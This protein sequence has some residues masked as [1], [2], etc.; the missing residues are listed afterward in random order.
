MTPAQRLYLTQARSD[1][2]MFRRFRAEPQVAPC[3]LLH[4]LQMATELLGKASRARHGPVRMSHAAFV[5]LLKEVQHNR[6]AQQVCGFS[7]RQNASWEQAIR[8]CILIAQ[9][10]ERL[11]PA[12]CGDGPNPEY[13]WPHAEAHGRKFMKITEA[14]FDH[15]EVFL[16]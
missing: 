7:E 8:K 14:L 11:A 12:L 3:H 1:L 6:E 5:T 15:A 4:Y 9:R 13:P 2:W 16:R 10:I